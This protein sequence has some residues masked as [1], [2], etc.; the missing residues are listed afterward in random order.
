MRFPGRGVTYH[1]PGKSTAGYTLFAPIIFDTAFLIDLE[2]EVVHQWQLGKAGIGFCELLA[3][4]N[5][6]IIEDS[7]DGPDMKPGKGGMLREY[8]WD[9]NLVWEHHD[10]AQHHDARRLAN[11]NTIYIAWEL[12]DDATAKRVR[13]GL[14]GTE[15]RN[16][17][18]IYGDVL[19]EID[20][21]GNVVWEWRASSLEIEKYPICPLCKRHE[22]AHANTLAPLANG[23]IMVSF[24]VLNLMVVIDRQTGAVKWEHRDIELGHPHD[25]HVLENGNVLVFANG[26]HARDVNFSRVIEFDYET[27]EPVWE[28]RGSP[29]HS[30]YSPH[31]SGVQRLASGNTLICEG[32]KGCI[33]ETTPEGE[34]VWEFISPHE[35][36]N[37]LHGQVNWVFRAKRYGLESP[38]IQNRI[39]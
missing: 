23:D 3:N 2:G 7:G 5:L 39:K 26:I 22:F 14:P 29:T 36:F 31:I 4:G 37:P 13:G 17:E 19:R 24:R 18:G 20:A 34:I 10:S 25:C 27:R 8:D 9:G 33:F 28:F 35:T 32:A 16:P 30:F 15:H 12:L 1:D 6:F 38:Q 21:A 11:G